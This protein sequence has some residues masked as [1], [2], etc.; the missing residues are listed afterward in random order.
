MSRVRAQAVAEDGGWSVFLPGAPISADGSTFDEAITEMVD[1]LREYAADW[2][3]RL[4]DAPNH[5][6]Q[7]GLVQLINLNDDDRLRAWLIEATA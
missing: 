7:R 5:R 1:S 4:C 6:R 3:K 2:Q